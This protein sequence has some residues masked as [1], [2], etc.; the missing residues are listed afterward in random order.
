[1]T[2]E[3]NPVQTAV[4]QSLAMVCEAKAALVASNGIGSELFPAIIAFEGDIPIGYAMLTDPPPSGIGIYRRIGEAAGLMVAGWHASALAL[5]LESYAEE[6]APFGD[7]HKSSATLAER[8]VHDRG[9]RE[10]LWVAYANQLGEV[11]MGVVTYTQHFGRRIETDAPT[12]S[13]PTQHAD[14]DEPGTYPNLIRSALTTLEHKPFPRGAN[15]ATA[16]QAI[17]QQLERIGYSVFVT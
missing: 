11:G 7:D 6:R 16:R 15:R 10:A 8:Y 3:T 12:L 17:A 4:I 5:A 1:V 13:D 9:V 2:D 14:F